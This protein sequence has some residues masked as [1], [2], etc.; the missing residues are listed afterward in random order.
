MAALAAKASG[1]IYFGPF[2]VTSQVAIPS[3]F[4]SL[5]SFPDKD[6]PD[7]MYIL[8]YE[9]RSSTSHLSPSR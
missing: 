2:V 8:T 5:F 4:F 7:S 6:L 3:L 9:N 1:P